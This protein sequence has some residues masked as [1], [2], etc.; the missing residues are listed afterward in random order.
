MDEYFKVNPTDG[1]RDV[2]PENN[3]M[4]TKMNETPQKW[5]CVKAPMVQINDNY[6]KDLTP[7]DT[8]EIGKVPNPGRFCFGNRTQEALPEPQR[9][10]PSGIAQ[11][12]RTRDHHLV[13]QLLPEHLAH[14]TL[15]FRASRTPHASHSEAPITYVIYVTHQCISK[16]NHFVAGSQVPVNTCRISGSV[17]AS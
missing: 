1:T 3:M 7:K 9:A 17:D 8:E 6:Y 12:L 13:E 10:M 16:I 15:L 2:E 11:L 4:D 5:V 14:Y